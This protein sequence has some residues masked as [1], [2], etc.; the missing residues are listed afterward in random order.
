MQIYYLKRSINNFKYYNASFIIQ[1]YSINDTY[2]FNCFESCQYV[3]MKSKFKINKISKIILTNLHINNLSGLIG[4]L[5]SLNLIGRIDSLHIY[6]PKD[7]IYYLDLCKKYSRTNFNYII[8]VHILK[9]GLIINHCKYRIY[10]FCYSFQYDFIVIE[11]QKFG[12]FF[13]D[14]AQKNYLLPSPLYSKLKQGL[15]F[16]LP[17]GFTLNGYS[18]TIFNMIGNQLIF[19]FNKYYKRKILENSVNSNIIFY[20]IIFNL[21]DLCNY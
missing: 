13:L 15:N 12:K 8:Y 18:F 14:K 9:T 11:S 4:L 16:I 5:S 17:D 21:Y 6:G 10:S 7:I 2:L 1:F 20:L 19:C 3:I